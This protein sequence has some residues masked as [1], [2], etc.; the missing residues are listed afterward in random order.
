MGRR[1]AVI[2]FVVIGQVPLLL[3]ITLAAVLYLTILEVRNAPLSN[4]GKVWWVLL[5]TLTH[6]FGY[7]ALRIWLVVRR[8]REAEAAQR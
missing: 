5:V 6:A 7:V 2:I 8:R 1:G 3:A 4:Q